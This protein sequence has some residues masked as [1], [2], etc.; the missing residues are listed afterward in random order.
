MFCKELEI[1]LIKEDRV[2]DSS[3]DIAVFVAEEYDGKVKRP[4]EKA[5]NSTE[6]G[7]W[8]KFPAKMNMFRIE[9]KKIESLSRIFEAKSQFAV[10]ISNGVFSA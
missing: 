10:A 4:A 6:V 5:S 1:K 9:E 3:A 2:M 8:N 7:W